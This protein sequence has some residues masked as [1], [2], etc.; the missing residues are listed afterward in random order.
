MVPA[1]RRWPVRIRPGCLLAPLELRHGVFERSLVTA[2]GGLARFILP[3]R[4]PP[5]G[6]VT[7]IPASCQ[8]LLEGGPMA[9]GIRLARRHRDGLRGKVLWRPGLGGRDLMLT[10]PVRRIGLPELFHAPLLR[11]HGLLDLLN[12]LLCGLG[13]LQTLL[14]VLGLLQLPRALLG[15]VHRASVIIRLAISGSAGPVRMGWRNDNVANRARPTLSVRHEMAGD[16][17]TP[18]TEQCG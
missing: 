11:G 1:G 3:W 18:G 5:V 13:F 2:A 6:I 10:I 16:G 17:N 9:I 7:A 14:S 8:R 15:V 4:L 12:A